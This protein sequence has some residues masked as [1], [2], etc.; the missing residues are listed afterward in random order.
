MKKVG[1][2]LK[3]LVFTNRETFQMVKKGG[4]RLKNLIPVNRAI[5][6]IMKK[7]GMRLKKLGLNEWGDISNGQ[8]RWY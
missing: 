1:L 8:K 6:E 5:F 3:N 4:I 7:V 2:K